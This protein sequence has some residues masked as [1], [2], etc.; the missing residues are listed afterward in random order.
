MKRMAGL[1]ILCCFPFL[2]AMA[3]PPGQQAVVP[4]PALGADMKRV[5]VSGIDAG[6]F[7]AGQLATAFSRHF[8][9]IGVIGAGPYFCAGTYSARS[10]L[11][12]VVT[13][14]TAPASP[15][16]G[17]GGD[18]AWQK[19]REFAAAGQIDP[20]AHLRRQRVYVFSG[21]GDRVVAPAVSAQVARFYRLA[22]A[23]PAQIQH[24]RHLR[25]GHGFA[26][27]NP[28]DLPCDAGKA[29]FFI[30]CGF[31]GA[32]ELLRHLH[33]GMR[34]APVA[35]GAVTGKLLRV[36]QAA[37]AGAA[38][39]GM[40]ATAY[41]FVPKACTGGK[42]AVHVALHGCQQAA[43]QVAGRFY[44][45]LGYNGFADPNRLIVL[46]PQVRVS[47]ENPQACWDF[48]GYSTGDT[49]FATRA[50]PQ[51]LAIMAMLDRLEQRRK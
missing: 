42:C 6:G 3:Q 17:A 44:Q 11:E 18:I 16:L 21:A 4:L 15:A 51:M 36:D 50:A 2:G 28:D 49:S 47:R 43:S 27:D 35:T 40:D 5:T 34:R 46:Y 14:C 45:H 8:R 26:T 48:W 23:A 32:H 33:P 20:L 37:F 30:N 29:P 9:G 38:Q 19:A 12:N 7:M 13:A 41:L 1:S 24:A 31:N 39:A 10:T 22:G 25:A